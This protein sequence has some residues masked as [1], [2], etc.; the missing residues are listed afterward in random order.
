MCHMK[1]TP[2]S[3]R[4]SA[5][6]ECSPLEADARITALQEKCRNLE[7]ECRALREECR[8]LRMQERK[9]IWKTNWKY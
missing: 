9:P 2:N 5:T 6:G 4:A 8:S 1:F 7:E 3:R